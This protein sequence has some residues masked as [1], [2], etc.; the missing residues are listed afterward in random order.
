MTLQTIHPILEALGWAL[1]HFVWQGTLLALLLLAFQ[2][3]A[4][5]SNPALRYAAGCIV[6]LLM[7]SVFAATVFRHFPTTPTP[8]IRNPLTAAVPMS[9][10]KARDVS[11]AITPS[12]PVN[13]LPT[14]PP[15]WI[16]CVWLLGVIAL[17]TYT[18]IGLALVQRL[19]RYG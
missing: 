12:L 3:L 1:L 19:K 5:R 9:P 16:A 17:S 2:T 10:I 15:D 18:A 14:G 6:M 13:G 4:R 8:V 7:I 11:A